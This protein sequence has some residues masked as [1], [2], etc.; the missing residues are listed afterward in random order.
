MA[1]RYLVV[2]PSWV[3]DMVMVQSLLITLK[4]HDP[5][6]TVDLLAPGWSL[7]VIA[8]MPQ[9]RAAVEMPLGHGEWGFS[10]RRALGHRLRDRCYSHAIVLPRS[11]KSALIPFFAR[12]PKRTGYRGEMRYGLLNDIRNLDKSLLT[13]TVHRFVALGWPADT[14]QPPLIAEPSLMI[15][16]DN[17]AKL[18]ET[19]RL[20]SDRPVVALMPGAEYGPA[21]CWPLEYFSELAALLT[22]RGAAVWVLGSDKDSKAGETIASGTG[23][24]NLCGRTEL[25]DAIDL[26]S[27][28]QVA[29]TNDSGLMHVAAAV[30]THVVP[31]YGSTTPEYTPALT[32]EKTVFYLKLE[33]S[34]CFQRTCPLGHLRCLKEIQPRQVMSAVEPRL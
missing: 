3:G 18:V 34:P 9:V 33:C 25:R 15:D 1:E 21:K 22:A 5:A 28:A 20:E 17:R 23:A 4:K 2:G 29:V 8:R 19:L 31:I 13:T 14:P 32:S 16:G 27:L 10:A 7:P 30:G 6:N 12:I 11:L 26:L 24:I